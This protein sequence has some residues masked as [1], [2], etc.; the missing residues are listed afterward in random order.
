MWGAPPPPVGTVKEG[1]REGV[2]GNRVT[3]PPA[4]P[5]DEDDVSISECACCIGRW[6]SRPPAPPSEV[7]PTI[8]ISCGKRVAVG[9][10]ADCCCR[11]GFAFLSRT[12]RTHAD[13]A[14]LVSGPLLYEVGGKTKSGSR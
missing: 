2:A 4:A 14:D 6:G 5:D 8:F 13:V 3:S 9:S 1:R 12:T 7:S 11:L 10:D